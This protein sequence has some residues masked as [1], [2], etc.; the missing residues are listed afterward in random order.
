MSDLSQMLTE[1]NFLVF[2]MP[3][4]IILRLGVG[5]P[6]VLGTYLQ[7]YTQPKRV[8]IMLLMAWQDTVKPKYLIPVIIVPLWPLHT[9]G[10]IPTK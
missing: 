6:G 5:G 1:K 3:E 10:P 8:Q 4:R 2:T 9:L 7:L